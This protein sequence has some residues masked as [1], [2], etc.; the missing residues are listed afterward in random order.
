MARTDF[1]EMVNRLKQVTSLSDAAGT[2]NPTFP[3]YLKKYRKQYGV[4]TPYNIDTDP[5]NMMGNGGS[6]IDKFYKAI[7]AQESGGNY[8]SVN[9]SSGALG[10]YQIMPSNLPSWSKQALGR[11]VSRNEFLKSRS[12]QD[13]IAQSMLRS[14][15]SK[16]GYQGAAAAWYGGPGVAKYWKRYTNQQGSYPSIK[17]YVEQV[18]RRM[19]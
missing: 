5:F 7:I 3:D 4:G 6:K 14:Y 12:L 10:A 1:D 9:S 19:G 16:Y 15:V 8:G 18:M 17:R 13:Q 11:S 2:P